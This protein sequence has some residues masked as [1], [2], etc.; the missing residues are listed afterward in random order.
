MKLRNTKRI[1]VKTVTLSVVLMSYPFMVVAE[2]AKTAAVAEYDQASVNAGRK[3]SGIATWRPVPQTA[4]G[5]SLRGNESA[6]ESRRGYIALDN[7]AV[8]SEVLQLANG[9]IFYKRDRGLSQIPQAQDEK[10]RLAKIDDYLKNVRDKNRILKDVGN[11]RLVKHETV[12]EYSVTYASA[13]SEEAYCA[14][15]YKSMDRA[16]SGSLAKSAIGVFCYPRKTGVGLAERVDE[17]MNLAQGLEFDGGE[18][19]QADSLKDITKL[20]HDYYSSQDQ[21]PPEVV[22][23]K[24][25]YS[26]GE[27]FVSG[28]ASDG[29]KLGFIKVN[30]E[31]LSDADFAKVLGAD[32]SFSIYAKSS[33]PIDAA[34]ITIGDSFG[35]ATTLRQEKFTKVA[36]VSTGGN[37]VTLSAQGQGKTYALLAGVGSYSDALLPTLISPRYDIEKV[38]AAMSGLVGIP[39][40]QMT[41]LNN[42]SKAEFMKAIADVREKFRY[43]DQFMVYYAGHGIIFEQT[44]DGYWSFNDTKGG[45]PSSWLSNRE[46]KNILAGFSDGGTLLVVDSCFSGQFIN[47]RYVS[48]AKAVS[49]DHSIKA[50]LAFTSAGR[51][52]VPDTVDKNNSAFA[53]KFVESITEWSQKARAKGRPDM[54]GIYVYLETRTKLD[55]DKQ[56]LP[57]YGNFTDEAEKVDGG[58][59]PDFMIPLK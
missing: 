54:P 44:G 41:V 33:R 7:P 47:G 15:F 2:N 20:V 53:L 36:A 51:N 3:D 43:G 6:V 25:E 32:G 59:V 16:S 55:K 56:K 23:S 31:R 1:T 11:L 37:T 34:S 38:S 45:D 12:G 9:T 19:A 5:V 30:G 50:K 27:L 22:L 29:S 13:E 26:D 40:E 4:A 42:P 28:K 14:T 10:A 8:Y 48:D 49:Y 58:K 24:G 39:V 35:N 46:M 21:Q 18:L 17:V 57:Q 52:P